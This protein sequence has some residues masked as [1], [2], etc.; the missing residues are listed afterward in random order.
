MP[1]IHTINIDVSSPINQMVMVHV[2]DQLGRW[3]P[4]AHQNMEIRPGQQTICLRNLPFHEGVY[5]VRIES[6]QFHKTDKFVVLK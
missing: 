6:G 1:G 4:F 5:F 2:F 3:I